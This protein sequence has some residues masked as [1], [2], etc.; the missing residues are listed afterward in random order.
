MK[1]K[2]A[3]IYQTDRG[4]KIFLTKECY[5]FFEIK[6]VPFADSL[7]KKITKVTDVEGDISAVVAI[8]K[9]DIIVTN[10]VGT[11]KASEKMSIGANT[12][13]ELNGHVFF[14][15]QVESPGCSYGQYLFIDQLKA[16]KSKFDIE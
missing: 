11:I 5:D 9:P 3:S 2:K 14:V 13:C 12:L 6:D 16:L 8:A 7:E 10:D 4:V 1:D 15:L